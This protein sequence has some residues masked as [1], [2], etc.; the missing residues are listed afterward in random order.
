MDTYIQSE[1]CSVICFLTAEKYTVLEIHELLVWVYGE[2]CMMI[3]HVC[4]WKQE[5]KTVWMEVD[6]LQHSCWPSN[7]TWTFET[8]RIYANLLEKDHLLQSGN[9]RYNHNYI[10][11]ITQMIFLRQMAYHLHVFKC[12]CTVAWS[13]ALLQNI[14]FHSSHLEF[15]FPLI[16]MLNHL[17]AFSLHPH[18]QLVYFQCCIFPVRKQ[19]TLHN[20]DWM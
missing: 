19:L 3:Q 4:K 11:I 1:L 7:S 13:T 15:L 20:S 10:I 16:N 2:G 14:N 6:V 8:Y 9:C 17:A 5:F 18:Q 12:W